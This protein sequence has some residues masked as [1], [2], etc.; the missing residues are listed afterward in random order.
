MAPS[1]SSSAV[2][3]P[4]S[5]TVIA[6]PNPGECFSKAGTTSLKLGRV[7]TGNTFSI[8]SASVSSK[9]AEIVWDNSAAAAGGTW[10]LVDI[11]STNGTQLNGNSKCLEGA[12]ASVLMRW[13]T[14][15]RCG[16]RCCIEVFFVA[17]ALMACLVNSSMN[18]RTTA[19]ANRCSRCS[20]FQAVSPPP[21][22]LPTPGRS[23]LPAARS[24]H[25]PPWPR[26]P[27]AGG[28]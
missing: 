19:L 17:S 28:H 2:P 11:G 3:R 12:R 20:T 6:G 1:S 5:L 16:H 24:G 13:R 25:H 18:A 22:A 23:T 9:H 21:P 15:E 14:R 8:K 27:A 26:H 10:F 7:K 4:I